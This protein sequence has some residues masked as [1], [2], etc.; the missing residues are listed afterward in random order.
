MENQEPKQEQKQIQQPQQNVV[1]FNSLRLQLSDMARQMQNIS[2]D[3]CAFCLQMQDQRDKAIKELE[4]YKENCVI[5][6]GGNVGI[7]NGGNSAE[8][9]VNE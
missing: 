1:N 9:K 2:A 6:D 3:L 5:T 4:E 8:L 7:G